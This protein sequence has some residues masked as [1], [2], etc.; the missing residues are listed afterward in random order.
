MQDEVVGEGNGDHKPVASGC[1]VLAALAMVAAPL[2]VAR[3][4]PPGDARPWSQPEKI[5]QSA[6]LEHGSRLAPR[7][8]GN[9]IEGGDR[10]GWSLE[11][12][13]TASQAAAGRDL[14]SSEDRA[15]LRN[16]IREQGQVIYKR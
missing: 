5:E 6:P 16:H 11:R 4:Q 13:V 3:A 2:A 15:A 12:G 8:P 9:R 14:L 1:A 10:A 7:I